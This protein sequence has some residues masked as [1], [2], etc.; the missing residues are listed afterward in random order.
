[1][2]EKVPVWD[3]QF[4]FKIQNGNNILDVKVMDEDQFTNDEIGNCQIDL[5]PYIQ[6][7]QNV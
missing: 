5:N 6:N 2:N 1:M 3:E 4:T 7:R